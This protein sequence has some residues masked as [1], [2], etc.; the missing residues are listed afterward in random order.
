MSAQTVN[1]HRPHGINGATADKPYKIRVLGMNS[2][3]SMD[4]VDCALCEFYQPSPEAQMTMKLIAY[5]EMQHHNE[6][7]KR[8]FRAHS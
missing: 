6:I 4:A 2:G 3:T 5:K 8:I 1:G 7:K